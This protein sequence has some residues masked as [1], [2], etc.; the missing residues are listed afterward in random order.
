MTNATKQT[1]QDALIIMYDGLDNI[2]LMNDRD[3][4]IV[5]AAKE[6]GLIE[7]AKEKQ[8]DIESERRYKR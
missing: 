7:W 6:L 1:V 8:D 5:D 2:D 3:W 4:A